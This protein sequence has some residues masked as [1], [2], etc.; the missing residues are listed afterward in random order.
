[1]QKIA[2]IERRVDALLV[3]ETL[4]E[5]KLP[6][7]VYQGY[8]YPVRPCSM[9]RVE[10]WKQKRDGVE[11]IESDRKYQK[12]HTRVVSRVWH[13]LAHQRS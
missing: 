7:Y 5:R 12:R 10:E 8:N 9:A 4:R 2:D 11:L 6:F 3:E 1:L 13:H